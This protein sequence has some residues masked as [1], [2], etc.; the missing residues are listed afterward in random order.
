MN[1]ERV[2]LGQDWNGNE[3]IEMMPVDG[4]EETSDME[5]HDLVLARKYGIGKES[6]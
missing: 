4:Y 3:I 6:E 2:Y 1:Y 5:Y